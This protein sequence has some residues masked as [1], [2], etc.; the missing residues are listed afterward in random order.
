MDLKLIIV[1]RYTQLLLLKVSTTALVA[2]LTINM[3]AEQ[4]LM[5]TKY[6][7]KNY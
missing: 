6:S 5:N 1:I 2:L 4:R 7:S 3:K